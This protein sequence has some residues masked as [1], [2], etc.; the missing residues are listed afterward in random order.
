VDS[1][2]GGIRTTFEGV[3]DA[4]VS[5]VAVTLKGGAKGLIVNSRDL[6]TGKR[7]RLTVRLIGQNGK[8]GDQF[9]LLG[10]DCGGTTNVNPALHPW[11]P[12]TKDT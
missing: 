4:P 8:R 1:V 10:N 7:A 3:P 9:P 6:C 5:K 12:P 11:A 2:H